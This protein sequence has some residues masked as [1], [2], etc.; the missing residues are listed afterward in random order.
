M[1]LSLSRSLDIVIEITVVIHQLICKGTD[2]VLQWVPSHVSISGNEHADKAAKQAAEGVGATK[3][4]L[5]PSFSDIKNSLTRA[6]W[7]QWV[8]EFAVRAGERYDIDLTPPCSRGVRFPPLS[9][10]LTGIIYRLRCD[11]WRTITIPKACECGQMVSPFHV[12]FK[13]TEHQEHFKPVIEKLETLKL[14]PTLSSVC[15]YRDDVG[16]DLAIMTAK[17]LYASSAAAYI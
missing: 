13:C 7:G 16:W 3:I 12:I 4:N 14:P 11:V 1:H 15:R 6:V 2:V 5:K 8:E 10:H 9:A 17:L